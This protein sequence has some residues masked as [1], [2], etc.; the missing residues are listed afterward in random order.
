MSDSIWIAVFAF[1]GAALVYAQ[2]VYPAAMALVGR[3]VRKRGQAPSV[4]GPCAS[5]TTAAGSQSA[6]AVRKRGQAPSVLGPCA[7]LTTTAGSQSP[8]SN[9]EPATCPSVSL[10]IPAHNEETTI[11]SKLENALAIDYPAERLEIIVASDGSSDRTVE[12][13]ESVSRLAERVDYIGPHIRVLDFPDRRGKTAVLNDAAREAAGEVLCLCDANVMFRPDALRRLAARLEDPA[14]GAVS[15]DV[16]L[17]SSESEFAEGEAAY[18]RL[19]R[20]VQLGESRI[21]SMMGVDGGMYVVRRELF[22]PL[23]DDTIVDDF[24]LSMRVIRQGRRVVYEPSA[25]ATENGTPKARQEFRRR[26]RLSAGAMQVLKRGEWP[27]LSRP[28]E[29]AQFVSHKVL[30]WAGPVWLLALV[31]SSAALWQAGWVFRI[32]ACGQAAFYALAAAAAA[33]RRLRETRAGGIAFYFTLSHIGM[34]VG[35]LRG[36]FNLQP[37]TWRRTERG[38]E[39][40]GTSAAY[41]EGACRPVVQPL[42]GRHVVGPNVTGGTLARTPGCDVEPLRGKD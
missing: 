27:P 12:I 23:P 5:L 7:S 21:G 30:R 36:L 8:F 26:V 13:A 39:G 32:A 18:Y 6:L 1:A 9:G 14:I 4:S 42:R 28:V 40:S 17:A 41:S 33:S 10:I 2:V 20:S 35:L 11:A 19:E 25:V 34:A 38:A 22:R 15:G 16:R 3:R 31:V 37:V 24:V 29:F